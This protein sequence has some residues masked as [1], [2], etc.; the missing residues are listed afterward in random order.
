[1]EGLMGRLAFAVLSLLV[2]IPSIVGCDTIRAVDP[3][4][5]AGREGFIEDGRTRRQEILERLGPAQASY[6]NGA[7]LIYHVN[8]DKDGRIGLQRDDR[9]SCDAYVL[10]FDAQQVLQR[11]SLV[12]HGCAPVNP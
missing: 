12:K 2:L 3:A 9:F 1:M 8:V 7:I 11:H 6:E 4:T 10:V 5:I